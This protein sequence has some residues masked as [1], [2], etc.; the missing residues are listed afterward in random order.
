MQR[1]HIIDVLKGI[2]IIFV[3]ILHSPIDTA[4]QAKLLF[5][6]WIMQA[7]PCFL[8]IT[9][10]V[11]ALSYQ[12]RNI[13]SMWGAYSKERVVEQLLRY[14]IPFTMIF[15]V[16]WLLFRI[17][18]LYTVNVFKYGVFALFQDYL[19]GGIGVGSYYFPLLIQNIFIFPIIYFVIKKHNFKGLLYCFFANILYELFKTS[20]YMN[21]AE[22]R[23][24]IFR[25]IFVIAAGCYLAI[26]K[27]EINKK[28][29]IISIIC[30][31]V[32]IGFLILFYYTNYH[33]KIFIYW[34][35]TSVLV[36]M[37]V[38]PLMGFLITKVKIKCFILELIGKASFN[39]F[40]IQKIYFV[41]ADKIYEIM[42]YKAFHIF[43]NV[44]NCILMGILF[45]Y[46]EKNITKFI[47]KKINLKKKNKVG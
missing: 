1:N 7:V 16:E 17:T 27:Y 11:Y 14:V 45:Y 33:P 29:Y 37:Y 4:L 43:L 13:E 41:F 35:D 39:I 24:L 15:V 40:L 12:R 21:D 2:L 19:R 36:C 34:T 30:A 20:Y 31:I 28:T 32:G 3:I 46:I 23:L 10:Y 5:P 25:Y 38:V 22:Y 9:G 8:F 44:I 6:F 18:G 26:G 47:I 42:P